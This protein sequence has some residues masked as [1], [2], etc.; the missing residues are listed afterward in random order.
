M[1]SSACNGMSGKVRED[2]NE[3]SSAEFSASSRF[4]L[5]SGPILVQLWFEFN[6]KIEWSANFWWPD[7][8]PSRFSRG[9]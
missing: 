6:R 9:T 1:R 8:R 7:I 5:D 3:L 2:Y 4:L